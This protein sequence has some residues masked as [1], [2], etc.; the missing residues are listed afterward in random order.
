MEDD[1]SVSDGLAKLSTR[2]KEA[3]DRAN[4]A[5]TQGRSDLEKTVS[6]VQASAEAGAK[7]IQSQAQ[8]ASANVSDTWNDV[9]TSWNAHIAKVKA[10]AEQRKAMFDAANAVTRADSAEADAAMAIDYAYSAIE[11]AEYAV[12]DAILAR[13]DAKD[14][15]A[16]AAR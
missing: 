10:D 5:A 1:M 14:A 9:Q 12:L 6:T 11:E 4:A 7:K 13:R 15:L 16:T 3:E 8:A 2:A